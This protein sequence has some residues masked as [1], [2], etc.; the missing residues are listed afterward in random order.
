MTTPVNHFTHR[1]AARRYAAARPFVHPFIVERIRQYTGIEQCDD[2]LDVACGTGQSTRAV[3]AIAKRVIGID[4]STEML[5]EAETVAGVEYQQGSAESLPFPDASFDLVTVGLALHWLNVEQ[6]L[7]EARRVMRHDSWLVPYNFVFLG[8]METNPQFRHWFRT[9][10]LARYP[11][12]A[13]HSRPLNE[14]LVESCGLQLILQDVLRHTVL[15]SRETFVS[16]VLTQSNVI[17]AVENGTDRIERIA[18]ELDSGAAP[19]FGDRE[20][21]VAFEISIHYLRPAGCGAS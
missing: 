14:A 20:Q 3:A 7:H 15:M 9:G 2:A 4:Q 10:Y 6:F 12:P 5:A 1:T 13:R 16:F 17:A 19:Y 11:G 21:P 8:D 18:E